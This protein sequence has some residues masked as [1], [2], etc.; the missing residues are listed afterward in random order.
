MAMSDGDLQRRQGRWEAL[1]SRWRLAETY[2]E[3]NQ[4]KHRKPKYADANKEYIVTRK[5]QDQ[6]AE[7]NE[8]G[9]FACIQK[10]D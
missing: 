6:N 7:K 1:P 9:D 4:G 5:T 10:I 8:N 3:I 2:E